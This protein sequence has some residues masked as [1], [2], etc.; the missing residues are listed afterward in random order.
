[1][2]NLLAAIRSREADVTQV[3]I[4]VSGTLD[5][6]P[7]RF[8][9]MTMNITAQYSD[10]ELFQKLITIAER[11]CIVTNTLRRALDLSIV[12]EPQ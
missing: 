5:G 4:R 11:A 8:T 3:R 2:S 6:A 1:M 9:A 7:E 12:L 10:R